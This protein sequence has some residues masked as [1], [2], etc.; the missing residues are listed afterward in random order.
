M[1]TDEDRCFAHPHPPSYR[2]AAPPGLTNQAR[3]GKGYSWTVRCLPF[4]SEFS[5]TEPLSRVHV[6]GVGKKPGRGRDWC[7]LSHPHAS[8]YVL[9]STLE[10]TFSSIIS[11]KTHLSLSG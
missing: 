7:F 8:A 9:H 5:S 4:K 3:K 6:T 2:H 1:A 11:L 10:I